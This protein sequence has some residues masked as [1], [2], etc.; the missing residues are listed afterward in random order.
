MPRETGTSKEAVRTCWKF[1]HRTVYTRTHK[2]IHIQYIHTC[3]CSFIH[4]HELL[5]TCTEMCTQT[6]IH[7]QTQTIINRYKQLHGQIHTTLQL[8]LESLLP[9][10]KVERSKMIN[11]KL[12][13]DKKKHVW[14]KHSFKVVQH[15][16]LL[17]TNNT[18]YFLQYLQDLVL[19]QKS[20]QFSRCIYLIRRLFKCMLTYLIYLTT[21]TST[22]SGFK[23]L[24][25]SC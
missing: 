13:E 24:H 16:T 8:N 15:Y 22:F 6:L 17:C 21:Q 11:C 23:K 2:H 5:R 9:L 14:N 4:E 3:K 25:V 19:M 20:K 12:F 1:K 7:T 18:N 10:I